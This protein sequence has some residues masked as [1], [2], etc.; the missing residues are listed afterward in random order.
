MKNFDFK[1]WSAFLLIMV[2]PTVINILRLHFIGAMP[3][4]WGFNIA[5]QIQWLNIIYE[6]I[7]EM[8][9][10]P[11][12]FMLAQALKENRTTLINNALGGL[13]LVAVI[14][15]LVSVVIF[16]SAETLV[17]GLNQA[18]ALVHQTAHYIKLESI[19]IMLS[20]ATE[21][22]IVY[23][24]ITDDYKNLIKLSLL[25]IGLLVVSDVFLIS[26]WNISLKLGVNGIAV[27]NILINGILTLFILS[28]GVIRRFI[29]LHHFYFDKR[30]FKQ[31]LRLGVFSGL[32]SLI[33]NT[34]FVLMI[35]GMVNQIGEQGAYWIAN[36]IIWGILLVPSLALG[37][38]IKRDVATDSSAIIS[39]TPFYM[40][41]TMVFAVLWLLSMPAW[42]WFLSYIL[43]TENIQTVTNIMKLQTVFYI[44]FMFNNGVLDSTIKGLG[45]TKYMLYQSIVIDIVYYSCVFVAYK[46]GFIEMS[47]TNISLIFGFGMLTDI[48]PTVWLY[49]KALRKENIPLSQIKWI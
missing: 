42:E 37:E 18:P 5:S 2:I 17:A 23:L 1:L 49:I 47:L 34:V 26:N 31:W 9:L 45:I 27:S 14:H 15:T 38:V 29:G 22:L 35:L 12:F 33:R 19:A 13:L 28:N 25:K 30:W 11:L 39:N 40:R 4:D 24:A 8:L 21:Y 7:K 10:V 46:M 32:E 36:S 3:N 41:L 16:F 44:T 6:V 43:K 20:V 48:F